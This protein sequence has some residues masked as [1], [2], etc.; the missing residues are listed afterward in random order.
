L[1]SSFFGAAAFA[2]G[3]FL[4]PRLGAALFRAGVEIFFPAFGFAATLGLAAFRAGALAVT[5]FGLGLVGFA[6]NARAFADF[7]AGVRAFVRDVERLRPFARVLM[8]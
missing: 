4:T 5:A 2:I 8:E 7:T 3:V 6:F 1:T